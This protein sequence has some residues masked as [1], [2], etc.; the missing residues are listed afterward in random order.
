MLAPYTYLSTVSRPLAEAGYYVFPVV[1]VDQLFK[2]NGLPTPYEMHEVSLDK[3]DEVLGADAVLYIHISEFGQK[4]AVLSS[5]TTVKAQATL[6]DVRTGQELWVG[7]AHAVEQSGDGGGGLLG[8]VIA[9]AVEQVLDSMTDRVVD[10][11]R[12]AN[13]Q[14]FSHRTRGVLLGPLR[15]DHEVDARGR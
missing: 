7:S 9:S 2:E 13:R 14:M 5:N 15:P 4:Y 10:V 11:A 12:V 3:I 8:M 1:V 6:V